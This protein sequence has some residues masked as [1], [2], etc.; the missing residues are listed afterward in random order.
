MAGTKLANLKT[1]ARQ[2]VELLEK[3]KTKPGQVKISL[4]PFSQAVRVDPIHKDENW[5]DKGLSPVNAEIFWGANPNRFT[6]FNDL[7]IPWAGC[8]EARP[9]PYDI[10]ETKA[11]PS[12]PATLFVPHFAPDEPD[13]PEHSVKKDGQWRL[14]SWY[15]NDYL[16]DNIADSNWKKVQG[17]VAKYTKTNFDLKHATSTTHRATGTGP[18]QGCGMQTIIPLTEDFQLLKDSIEAMVATGYTNIPLGAAW[19]WH[20]LSPDGPFS[21]AKGVPYGTPN[22]SKFMILMTDGQNTFVDEDGNGNNKNH[23]IYQSLGYAWQNRLGFSTLSSPYKSEAT[24]SGRMDT[25]LKL[26]CENMKQ[27]YDPSK[28][29]EKKVSIFTIGVEVPEEVLDVLEECA[30]PGRFYDV[31]DS[32]DMAA[33]FSKIGEEIKQLRLAK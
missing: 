33:V 1:A 15:P 29:K 10:Q 11:D 9:Q 23:S 28:P 3:A 24:R 18:N 4:V 26:L 8:V 5:I 21:A 12:T 20:T 30:D 27:P 22:V 7:Q 14:E 32:N 2:L 19:G 17:N 25:R 16:Y 6:L 31:Q 13:V